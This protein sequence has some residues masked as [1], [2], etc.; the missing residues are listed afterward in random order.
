MI[1]SE[2]EDEKGLDAMGFLELEVK[3]EPT[4]EKPGLIDCKIESKRK[5]PVK[6]PPHSCWF[7]DLL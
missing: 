3:V 4:D 7:E 1:K 6:P 2:P 5:N